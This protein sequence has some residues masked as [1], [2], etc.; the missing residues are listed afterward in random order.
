[1]ATFMNL[2]RLKMYLTF[3]DLVYAIF[4]GLAKVIIAIIR[5][6][7]IVTEYE[8]HIRVVMI[9]IM[10]TIGYSVLEART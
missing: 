8:I 3:L 5:P 10:Y 7:P 6:F 9:I 2:V 4:V 1:M